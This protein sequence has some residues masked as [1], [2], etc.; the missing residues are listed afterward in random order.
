MLSMKNKFTLLVFLIISSGS[1][2]QQIIE[3]PK[4]EFSWHHELIPFEDG[5]YAITVRNWNKYITYMYSEKGE[6]TS[7]KEYKGDS[8]FSNAGGITGASTLINLSQ[9]DPVTKKSYTLNVAKNK[10]ILYVTNE[11]FEVENFEIERSDL[12]M[13]RNSSNT[14]FVSQEGKIYWIFWAD[15]LGTEQTRDISIVCYNPTSKN[16]EAKKVTLIREESIFFD[17]IGFINGKPFF[18]GMKQSGIVK[19]IDLNIYLL[20]EMEVKKTFSSK[21]ELED[22]IKPLYICGIYNDLKNSNELTFSVGVA[23]MNGP[24]N[25]LSNGYKFVRMNSDNDM[26]VVS[27]YPEGLKTSGKIPM[28][29]FKNDSIERILIKGTENGIF[30]DVDHENENV[31]EPI[32]ITCSNDLDETYFWDFL[33]NPSRYSNEAAEAFFKIINPN[34]SEI[35][36]FYENPQ[37]FQNKNGHWVIVRCYGKEGRKLEII[38]N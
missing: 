27:W 24:L 19:N 10:L 3:L 4:G 23:Q 31:S 21:I 8:R 16:L 36:S 12:P 11:K 9:V 5:S 14:H 35:L 7:T 38:K 18:G 29:S 28:V 2:C 17:L 33:L 6:N 26:A 25:V 20:D 32:G 37:M 30:I 34:N 15:V 13:D 22:N 1:F